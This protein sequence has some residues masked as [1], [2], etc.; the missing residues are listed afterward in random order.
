M[1]KAFLIAW[2]ALHPLAIGA[3][4]VTLPLEQYENLRARANA[5]ADAAPRPPA[6]WALES[7]DYSVQAGPESARVV[8]T[9]RFTIYDDKWQSLPLGEAGAFI[10]ADFGGLEGRVNVVEGAWALQ[11]RGRGAHEVRLESAVPVVRDETATRPTWRFGLRFP[12]AAVVRGRIEAADPVEEVEAEGS[13]LVR[14]ERVDRRG[15]DRRRVRVRC[16]GRLP[17]ARAG[18]RRS[19]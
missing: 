2:L 10:R 13:G 17:P 18:R 19:R 7:A 12:A 3:Q 5:E 16:A 4:Q 15:R 8:Q 14:R 6:P 9:L 11:A 1:R